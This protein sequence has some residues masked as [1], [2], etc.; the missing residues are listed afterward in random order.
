[1]PAITGSTR[2]GALVGD[3]NGNSTISTITIVD[4]SVTG[5][6]TV[7]GV[8]GRNKS[9][10][11]AAYLSFTGLVSLYIHIWEVNMEGLLEKCKPIPNLEK[12]ILMEL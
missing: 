1:M 7:G 3:V 9:T 6:I 10:T 2:V 8:I 12:V 4:S 11:A 5:S